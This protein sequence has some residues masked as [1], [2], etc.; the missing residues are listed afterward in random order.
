MGD[1]AVEVVGPGAVVEVDSAIDC[2]SMLLES[3]LLGSMLLLGVG[4]R[5]GVELVV[6]VVVASASASAS[7]PGMASSMTLPR[8]ENSRPAIKSSS[9]RL[10]VGMAMSR[11]V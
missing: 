9:A 8:W 10:W 7:A 2:E 4:C 6:V 3:M 1:V 11:G 5:V